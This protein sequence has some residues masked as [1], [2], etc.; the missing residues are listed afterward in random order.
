MPPDLSS[1]AIAS[2]SHGPELAETTA[3]LVVTLCSEQVGAH[4]FKVSPGDLI[5]TEKLKFCD[6]NDKVKFKIRFSLLKF[7]LYAHKTA[8]I[9]I[10]SSLCLLYKSEKCFGQGSLVGLWTKGDKALRI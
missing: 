7:S 3:R 10:R 9:F 6:I 4:Q 1:P 5:Y 2:H 8:A